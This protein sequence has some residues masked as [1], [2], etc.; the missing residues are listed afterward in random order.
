M[1]SR[2]SQNLV[3][4]AAMST[5]SFEVFWNWL[6]QHPNCVLRV[7]T[8][9]AALY[10]DD[11][12]HWYIGP[13]RTEQVI[14][15]IRGKRLVGEMLIAPER[16]TYV[17]VVGE[18]TKGEYVFEAVHEAPTERAAVYIFAL[19]HGLEEDSEPEAATSHGPL[20]H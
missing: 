10:D 1:T 8:P 15:L 5:I 18:D 13:D 4:F 19:T 11:D 6:Q 12:L 14:Q 16:V 3:T 20:V 17:Q 9:E 2:L 7:T